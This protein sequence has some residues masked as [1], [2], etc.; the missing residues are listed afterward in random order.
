MSVSSPDKDKMNA[1]SRKRGVTGVKTN[2]K[3]SNYEEKM[4]PIIFFLSSGKQHEYFIGNSF[5][6]RIHKRAKSNAFLCVCVRYQIR[7]DYYA[8][9]KR[10]TFSLCRSASFRCRSNGSVCDIGQQKNIYYFDRV[11]YTIHI[12]VYAFSLS[13]PSY[14]WCVT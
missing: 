4:N 6:M 7:I 1:I 9:F 3:M 13:G 5:G 8:A 12:T 10:F 2:N 11:G 14:D